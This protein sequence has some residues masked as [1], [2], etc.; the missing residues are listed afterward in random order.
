MTS[1]IV[2]NLAIYR[3]RARV[4]VCVRV[5]VRVCVC[6]I[7]PDAQ[8]NSCT[9][10]QPFSSYNYLKPASTPIF[11]PIACLRHDFYKE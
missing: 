6:V 5:C 10:D 8:I 7:Q 1:A 2:Y 3:A 9:L 11:E 4:C